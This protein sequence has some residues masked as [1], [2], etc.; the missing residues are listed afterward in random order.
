MRS[1]SGCRVCGDNLYQSQSFQPTE[2]RILS[3][4]IDFALTTFRSLD[5]GNEW[6]IFFADL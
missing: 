4:L 3:K 1:L 6:K 5:N 2:S